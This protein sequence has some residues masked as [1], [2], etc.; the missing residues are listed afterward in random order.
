MILESITPINTRLAF[1]CLITPIQR[2]KTAGAIVYVYRT[3]VIVTGLKLIEYFEITSSNELMEIYVFIYCLDC[4]IV[5]FDQ[6]MCKKRIVYLVLKIKLF[7]IIISGW[8]TYPSNQTRPL[9]HCSFLHINNIQMKCYYFN[10]TL[11]PIL[12]NPGNK[13]LI[14]LSLIYFIQFS[15][16]SNELRLKAR[17]PSRR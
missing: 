16:T 1:D 2:W 4:K 6:K 7:N 13:V 9:L 12:Y 5:L 11:F 10:K 8:C 3:L 15:S 14:S 17:L